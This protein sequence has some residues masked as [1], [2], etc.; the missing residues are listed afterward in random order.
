MRIAS[1][2]FAYLEYFHEKKKKKTWTESD[3]S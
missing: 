3:S 2:A 1:F